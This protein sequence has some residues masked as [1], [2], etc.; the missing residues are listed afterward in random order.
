MNSK[1][2]M[3]IIVAVI[4]ICAGGAAVIFLHDSNNSNDSNTTRTDV[5]LTIFGNANGDDYID[6]S[7]VKMIE[8]YLN[9]NTTLSSFPKVS[10]LTAYGGSSHTARYWADADTDGDVDADDLQIV[11]NL[12][13]K[14]AGTK[15]KFYDV[16]S[17]IGTCTYPLTTYAVG[18]KSNYEAELI[19]GNVSNC[20]YVC[21]QVGENGAYASWYKAF[22][23]TGAQCFGSRFTPDY[24]VFTKD[25][26]TAPSY[27]LSGT[28]A[29]FDANMETTLSVIGTDVVRLPF[30]EDTTTVSGILT[31]GFLCDKNDAAHAYAEKADKV[32][33]TIQNYVKDIALENRPLVF[34]SYNGTSISTWHNGIQELVEAAG[35]RTP[36]DAGFTNGSIDGEG[37]RVMDP[38]WIVFDMY[39]GLLETNDQSAEYNYIYDQGSSKTRYFNAIAGTKA[40]ADDKVLILGQG[41][42]MGPASYIG[43]AYV[44]NHIYAD[45]P[46]F[47]VSALLKDYVD[48]YHPDYSGTDFMSQDCFDVNQYDDWMTENVSGYTKVPSAY[49]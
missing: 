31:L 4:V 5:R 44:F 32:L 43:I 46:Q 6:D 10:V 42:Y 18:Y 20:K 33:D 38:D 37:V 36:Y 2:I 45:A 15:V 24:E 35:A 41:V 48:T 1:S 11:K 49:A 29:W 30:W 28:R 16:D 21:N 19:L 3:A 27:M 9:G 23:D 22:N 47:D 34:A 39:Y 8:E 26:N 25:G 13:N 40:Y 7:D 14:K 17:L 12:I